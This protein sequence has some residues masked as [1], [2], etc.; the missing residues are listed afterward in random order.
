ML[1]IPF[2]LAASYLLGALPFGYVIVRALV[3]ADVRSAGSGS[4]GATN[5]T[6]RAGLKAGAA[7]YVLDLVKG[8]AAVLLMRTISDDP[9]W[10][11][12]AAVAAIIGHMFPVFLKFKGGKGVATGVGAYLVVAPLAVLCALVVW[13]ALFWRTRTVSLA[14]VVATGSVPVFTLLW[15]WLVLDRPD[16]AKLVAATCVGCALIILKHHENIRRLL[17]GTESRFDR[18]AEGAER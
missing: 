1:S 11:G 16:V 12:A 2:A 4:T 17:S 8:V 3:G 6:R 5:V 14:S 10:L 7:T 9:I 15:Y 18:G 13:I